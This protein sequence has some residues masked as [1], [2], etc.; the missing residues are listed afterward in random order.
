MKVLVLG[1]GFLGREF[2]EM[3]YEV[4]GRDKFDFKCY[5]E[6]ID[7][8]MQH[9]FP[10]QDFEKYDVIINCIG[11]SNTRYCEDPENFTNVLNINGTLPRLLSWICKQYN[12][13]F[14]H[15]STGCLYDEVGRPC[16]EEDFLAAHCGYTVSKYVGEMGCNKEHDLIIRPRLLF[17]DKKMETRNNLLQKLL[18]FDTFVDELNSVTWNRTIVEAV[19]ALLDNNQTGV[20]NV[21]NEGRHTIYE[22]ATKML[23][24]EGTKMSG[25][26]LRK[27]QG[28][29][30]VNNVMDI[31]KLKQ[32]YQP[33]TVEK[34]IETCY[35]NLKKK[36][37]K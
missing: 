32:F 7:Y 10:I 33:P 15:I 23:G 11:I 27:S 28:L 34:A 3:G 16:T 12:K 17:S 25:E 1:K 21:A 20:F 19:Q 4:W 9:H 26:Q 2:E 31:S 18:K 6:R 13:K 36:D 22:I 30:L 8:Y 5:R 14:V 37:Y 35:N 24:R 29:H